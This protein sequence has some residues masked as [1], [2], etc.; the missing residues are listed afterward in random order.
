MKNILAT[1]SREI[2]RKCRS[3]EFS[4]WGNAFSTARNAC[5]WH[6]IFMQDGHES[7]RARGFTKPR[8]MLATSLLLLLTLALFAP[9]SHAQLP[10]LNAPPGW[11]QVPQGTGACEV[12]KSCA[13]LAPGMIRDALGPSPLD[14]DTRALAAI[15]SS[16]AGPDEPRAAAWAA[17]AFKR[18][19]ADSVHVEALG[20]ANRRQNVVAEIRGRDFPKDYVLIAA[21]LDSPGKDPRAAAEN[22]AVLL[23]A[24]RVVHA[25]GNIP[26]R[27]IRFVLFA[28]D[29]SSSGGTTAGVWAYIGQHRGEMDRI[30]A[31]IALPNAA[32]SP[33]GYALANRPDT[34]AGVRQSLE[35]LRSLGVT[36]FT[37]DLKI[38]TAITPFWLEG[39]PTLVAISEGSTGLAKSPM[40]THPAQS[41][42]DPAKLA[43]LKHSVAV[44]AITAYALADAES[45]IGPRQS[46]SEVQ[47]TIR[48]MAL[49][50]KLKSSGLWNQW[51]SVQYGA[52]GESRK[53]ST[54]PH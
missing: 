8:S 41:G 14:A 9:N 5:S 53:P 29:G 44:G 19:G 4:A 22:A 42:I 16:P 34:L 47:Q 26:R 6:D 11:G 32:H 18:A 33:Q 2:G 27:S 38:P 3:L 24:L 15:L 10:P 37:Q 52:A 54:K 39:V 36:Q 7:A 30:V 31:A 51:Q 45:R 13:D 35:P 40:E 21:P 43:A 48:S 12:G 49:A 17:A 28:A 46:L 20:P 1:F 50:P 23:D 25:T